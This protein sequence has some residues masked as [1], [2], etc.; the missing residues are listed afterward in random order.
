MSY[1]ILSREEFLLQYGDAMIPFMEHDLEK[2]VNM[3]LILCIFEEL[4]SLN[5][6]FHRSEILCFGKAE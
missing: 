2:T 3:E 1:L 5:I 6:N 4:S